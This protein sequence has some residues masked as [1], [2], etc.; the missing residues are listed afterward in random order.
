MITCFSGL[1][2]ETING[3]PVSVCILVGGMLN[4]N[5][6]TPLL[7]EF[8]FRLHYGKALSFFEA[9]RKSQK[10]FPFVN[11]AENVEVYLCIS[12]K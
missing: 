8:L 6:L 4:Q 10:L 11:K 9:N 1:S 3:G 7:V 12:V 5:S 2:D